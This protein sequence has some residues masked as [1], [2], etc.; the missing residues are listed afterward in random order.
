[1]TRWRVLIKVK[2][3]HASETVCKHPCL[4]AGAI[5]FCEEGT[6]PA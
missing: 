6:S 1:M 3:A 4:L 5:S 2:I